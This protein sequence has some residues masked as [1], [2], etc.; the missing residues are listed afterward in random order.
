MGAHTLNHT[1][2]SLPQAPGFGNEKS[3]STPQTNSFSWSFSRDAVF[4]RCLREYYYCYYGSWSGWREDAPEPVR[5]LYILKRLAKRQQWAGQQVHQS[6]AGWLRHDRGAAPALMED[7]LAQTL[8]S[9]MR[10]DFRQSRNKEYRQ[11]TASAGGLFEHEYNV[12][13]PDSSWKELAGHAE[14][15]LRVFLRSETAQQLRALPSTVELQVETRMRIS[16]DGIPVLAQPDLLIRTGQEVIIYDW[17]TG[18]A[19]GR[20]HGLQMGCYALAAVEQWRLDPAQVR[21]WEFNL[22]ENQL[23]PHPADADRLEFIRDYI[24]DSADEMVFPLE[25]AA[26]NR[27]N[28]EGFDFTDDETT[29]HR[30]NF[31]KVC[32]RWRDD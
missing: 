27:A 5:E 6:I 10:T 8:L 29:C 26:A 32:P 30:C 18:T 14:Q 23:L 4:R 3:M 9:R 17:K 28:E 13:V 16:L 15:C 2:K 12:E 22:S 19:T 21:V 1:K 11:H 24:R 31:L 7:E 20:D 25:D